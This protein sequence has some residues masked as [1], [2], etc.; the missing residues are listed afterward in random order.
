MV[1]SDAGNE[2]LVRLLLRKGARVKASAQDG[3]TALHFAAQKGHKDVLETVNSNLLGSSFEAR[4]FQIAG[5]RDAAW[6]GLGFSV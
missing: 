1:G 6:G 3:M 2:R 5:I 4:R